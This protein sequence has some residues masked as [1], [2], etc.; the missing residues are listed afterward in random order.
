MFSNYYHKGAAWTVREHLSLSFAKVIWHIVNE[1]R[2][3]T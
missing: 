3:I 1:K 2:R